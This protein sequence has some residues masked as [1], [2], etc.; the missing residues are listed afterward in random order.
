VARC[1]FVC[2]FRLI[3]VSFSLESEQFGCVNCRLEPIIVTAKS[4]NVDS[5]IATDFDGDALI[6]GVNF[7]LKFVYFQFLFDA[8]L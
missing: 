4:G 5:R 7:A 8:R 1:V 2:Q 6:F 3:A